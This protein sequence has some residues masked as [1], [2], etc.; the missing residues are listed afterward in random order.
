MNLTMTV[1]SRLTRTPDGA[2]W[3]T[4]WLSAD[5]FKRYLSSFDSVRVLARIRDEP[6]PPAGAK[7]AD[8]E[9]VEFVALPYYVGPWQYLRRMGALKLAVA[10]AIRTDDAL[11]IRVPGAVGDIVSAFANRAGRPFAVEV[12][13]DPREV[14]ATGVKSRFA[15]LFLQWATRSL[16]AQCARACAAAYV[17]RNPLA[18]LYPAGPGAFVTN[19]SSIDLRD[20][21]F[22]E[23][24][25]RY[26]AP[27]S[28][29]RIVSVGTMEQMYKGFDVL[30]KAIARCDPN[31][32]LTTVG[33]GKHRGE[34]EALA[35]DRGCAD[36]IMFAGKLP[37]GAG[38]R[39]ALDAADL[40]VLATRAEGLPRAVIEAMARGLPCIGTRVCGMPELLDEPELAVPE[41]F[42]LLH[43]Q[44]ERLAADPARM[45]RLSAQNIERACQYHRDVL[46]P[47]RLQ[48]YA[49]L[50]EHTKR[51]LETPTARQR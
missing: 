38:V 30:I 10:K 23:G 14:F 2:V 50:I 47:R 42:D 36:R 19:Y 8:R 20:E 25:R 48:M 33:D 49:A 24:P 41:R 4:V 27:P 11:L 15:P 22:A 45:T 7:R 12:V 1:E 9:G 13:S 39:Q 21:A 51:W 35:R 16:K 28:P 46:Q 31:V 40:F 32:T 44:I 18:K 43:P 5:F 6:E 3:S 26:D 37:P 34:L 29:C 17:A